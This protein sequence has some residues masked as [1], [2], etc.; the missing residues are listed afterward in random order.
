MSSEAAICVRDLTKCYHLYEKPADRLKQFLSRGKRQYFREF[1]ALSGVSFDVMP[2]EVLGIV[3][4]NGAGKSTLLQLL[5]GTL[6]PTSGDVQV[7]G[8]IAALLELGAGFNPEFSGRENV[9]M[10]ASILGLSRTEVEARY[11]EIVDFSGIRDF[12]DQPVKTY[13][14]G[15]YVRLAFAVAT[16]VDPD[17]LVIDEALSVGDGA[18]ARKS[19]DRIMRLKDE[20]K[21]IL[22]CSHSLYQVEA[23]CDRVLWLNKGEIRALGDPG[24]VNAA[25]TAFLDAEEKTQ[26]TPAPIES[27]PAAPASQSRITGV[28]LRVDGETGKAAYSGQSTVA[29]TV[30][31][32]HAEERPLTIAVAIFTQDDRCITSVSSAIDDFVI[33]CGKDGRGSATVLFEDIG[34][35]KG[36]YSIAAWLLCDKALFIHDHAQNACTLEVLQ[37]DLIQGLVRFPHYWANDGIC[38]TGD[39]E[40]PSEFRASF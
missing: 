30:D 12:I 3:G 6:S 11:D 2:G 25:Y 34:L 4:R 17:I 35:L 36:V 5:C 10:S 23:L 8:R 32:V 28:E 19:F 29:V 13:S 21:T 20:G 14:S 26:A 31:F 27:Q 16:T 38:Q 33:Q 18:F 22:F 37:S 40:E 39:D 24:R 7:R 15:M 9:F 1:W